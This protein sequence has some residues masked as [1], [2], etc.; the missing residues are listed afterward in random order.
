MIYPN[1]QC[2]YYLP[3]VRFRQKYEHRFGGFVFERN[4]E[5]P[6]QQEVAPINFDDNTVH[7][8]AT[9][10]YVINVIPVPLLYVELYV[11]IVKPSF[12]VGDVVASKMDVKNGL[13]AYRIYEYTIRSGRVWY[14]NGWSVATGCE[15]GCFEENLRPASK[16]EMASWQVDYYDNLVKDKNAQRYNCIVK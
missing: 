9:G 3:Y 13:S 1:N 2:V 15:S 8:M 14:R 6:I 12:A 10:N 5:F 11:K 7:I 4:D 16:E